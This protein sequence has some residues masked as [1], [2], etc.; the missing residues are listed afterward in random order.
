LKLKKI[1]PCKLSV[2]YEA[3]T[4]E[5]LAKKSEVINNFKKAPVPGFRPGK[6]SV[7][8]ISIHYRDQID[9]ALKRALAE[10]AFH[11]TLFEKKIKPHGAPLFNGMLYT[12]GKFSCDFEVFVKPEFELGNY[13]NLDIPKPTDPI[14]TIEL[15]EKMMQELR[16][17]FGESS[18]YSDED[19]VTNG[20][21]V[22]LD[23][24]G[25]IDNE[26]V[27]NLSAEGEMLTV[28]SSALT[29]FDSN[30]LGIKMGETKEFNMVVP[31]NG[32]PSL[33]GK[34][35]HFKVTVNMGSRT[36]P[37]AL[38]DE[39][40]IKFGKKD[41]L[42]LKEFVNATAA[43]RV[44]NNLK[45]SINEAV[46]NLLVDSNKIDVPSWMSISEA[47]YLAHQSKLDWETLEDQDR[48]KFLFMANKNVTLSLVLDKIRELEPEAQLSDQEV[49]EVIKQN[50]AKTKVD[51]PL[52]DIIKEMN[53]T[54]Y[55]QI[56]FS[57]I[58]DENT[59]DFIVKN[60]RI[61]E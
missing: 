2:H 40:A 20:D 11:N 31:D 23:Y 26:K 37:C 59:L 36:I 14:S 39:L 10:D 1:E 35:V 60:A 55:L 28:G 7:A 44:S 9:D 19:F 48:G 22:I 42:E 24:E 27:E 3:D 4:L 38:D 34:T 15:S 54:G 33:V 49:F 21:N 13:K 61:I 46:C 6:A 30:L 45:L 41:Y 18:P 57:R 16:V 56:L 25:F 53:R 17:R 8:A 5:V 52:D 51:K 58:K 32:M 50:L 47:K 43:A 29:E 12:G